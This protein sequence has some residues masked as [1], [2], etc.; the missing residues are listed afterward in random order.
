[1]KNILVICIFLGV[2]AFIGY[3]YVVNDYK[4]VDNV[5]LEIEKA[6]IVDKDGKA[7]Y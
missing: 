5:Y 7:L 4:W 2:T 3:N 6:N 1:M